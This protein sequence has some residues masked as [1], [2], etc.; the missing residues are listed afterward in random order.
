MNLNNFTLKAQESV[1]KGFDIAIA[2]GQQAVECAHVLKGVMSES[3]GITNFLFGKL[4]VNTHNLGKEID[5]LID[6]FPRVSGAE[7][8]ISSVLSDALRKSDDHASRMKDKF[9]SSEHL[10]MG[11][12][13]TDDKASQI[14][15]DHGVAMKELKAAIGELRKGANVESQSA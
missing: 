15:K 14:L 11:I 8:Y 6:S 7:P 10:L 1:Q 9:V 3:E 12:L 2:K 4:G 5:R 13:D